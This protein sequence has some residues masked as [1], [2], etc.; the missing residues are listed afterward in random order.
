MTVISVI[1][2]VVFVITIIII[3]I[4]CYIASCELVEVF[5]PM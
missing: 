4:Y 3:T 1:I 5:C 2:M